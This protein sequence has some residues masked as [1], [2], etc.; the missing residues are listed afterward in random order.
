MYDMMYLE[1]VLKIF[2]SISSVL[3]LS[4]SLDLYVS[5]SYF[6]P[7]LIN[8][9][10]SI[11]YVIYFWTLFE[12][13]V[14]K[15][16]HLNLGRACRRAIQKLLSSLLLFKNL[17]IRI[18]KTIILPVVLYGCETWSLTLRKKHTLRVFESRV[19]RRIFGS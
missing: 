7:G 5:Q 15:L 8:I 13:S 4:K 1:G 17:K 19:Q 18:Q 3:L 2:I 6:P 9:L 11:K 14:Y 10:C 12:Q 16:L